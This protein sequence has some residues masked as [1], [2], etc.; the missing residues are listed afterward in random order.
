MKDALREASDH[1]AQGAAL[2][3]PVYGALANRW[4]WCKPNGDVYWLPAYSAPPVSL[5]KASQ[6]YWANYYRQGP[7]K[8]G[9]ARAEVIAEFLDAYDAWFRMPDSPDYCYGP[10]FERMV[11]ARN[12]VDEVV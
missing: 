9:A 1:P 6:Q 2:P 5:N 4:G 12:R 8:P 3:L 11:E 7:K 10:E